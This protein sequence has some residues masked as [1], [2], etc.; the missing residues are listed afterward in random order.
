MSLVEPSWWSSRAILFQPYPFDSLYMLHTVID[1]G[2]PYSSIVRF[3][4]IFGTF[5]NSFLN[6]SNLSALR[7]SVVYAV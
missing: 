2:L 1:L 5:Q 3:Q 7:I 6:E 4:I